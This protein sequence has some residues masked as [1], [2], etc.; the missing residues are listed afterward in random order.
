MYVS[1]S[2]HR[3]GSRL[4]CR[5]GP[6]EADRVDFELVALVCSLHFT[7]QL[8]SLPVKNSK[9]KRQAQIC[10]KMLSHMRPPLSKQRSL[11]YR[12]L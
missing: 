5:E 9:M 6:S 1:S 12:M 2:L 4:L 8:H 10:L 7:L 11:T 3:E